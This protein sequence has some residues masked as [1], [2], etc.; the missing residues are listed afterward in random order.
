M[1]TRFAPVTSQQNVPRESKA[2]KQ[3]KLPKTNS[4][5]QNQ[6][7]I[8]VPFSPFFLLSQ[9]RFDFIFNSMNCYWFTGFYMRNAKYSFIHSHSAQLTHK[10]LKAFP[11]FPSLPDLNSMNE[12]NKKGQGPPPAKNM[13]GNE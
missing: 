5:T 2:P 7:N 6:I 8:L 12:K 11:L 13:D 1:I 9:L 10:P 3:N 4:R